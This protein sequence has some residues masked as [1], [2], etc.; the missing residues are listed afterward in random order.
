MFGVNL[1]R[2]LFTTILTFCLVISS[3]ARTTDSILN[4]IKGN[5]SSWN[6]EVLI[7]ILKLNEKSEDFQRKLF[8][9]QELK[10]NDRKLYFTASSRERR[11]KRSSIPREF[12]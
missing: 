11:M 5:W 12:F 10:R 1:R 3:H 7:K 6:G 9:R 2:F 4:A 8:A